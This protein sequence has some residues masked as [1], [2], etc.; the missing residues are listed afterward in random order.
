[1]TVRLLQGSTYPINLI[2]DEARQKNVA[3]A[4]TYGNHTSSI[5]NPKFTPNMEN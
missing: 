2:S 3:A 1:M 4:L 5:R